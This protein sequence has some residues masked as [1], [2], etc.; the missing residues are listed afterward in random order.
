MFFQPQSS[1]TLELFFQGASGSATK[2]FS[3]YTGETSILNN[4]SGAENDF[5]FVD[6]RMFVGPRNSIYGSG[7]M[8]INWASKDFPIPQDIG[9]LVINRTGAY[10]YDWP[11]PMIV[12]RGHCDTDGSN[13]E[14]R[15][16]IG[17]G[18]TDY[19]GNVVDYGVPGMTY[20]SNNYSNNTFYP[21]SAVGSE[22]QGEWQGWRWVNQVVAG[23]PQRKFGVFQ[24]HIAIGTEEEDGLISNNNGNGYI[25][26]RKATVD[27]N[28]AIPNNMAIYYATD[29]NYKIF[30]NREVSLGPEIS[31]FSKLAADPLI[32]TGVTFTNGLCVLTNQHNGKA[33]SVNTT[34]NFTISVTGTVPEGF[35]CTCFM[36]GTGMVTFTGSSPLTLRNSLGLNKNNGRWSTVGLFR[37]GNNLFFYGDVT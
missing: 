4:V 23:P 2:V 16:F 33:L 31:G 10:Y 37:R 17:P 1:D 29:G 25:K 34:G 36:E 9:G 28:L 12:L 5:R 22:T 20:L 13:S 32:I 19:A 7:Q 24:T 8:N 6:S 14:M 26:L 30:T 18:F 27:P 21:S 11:D 3:V 35:S 15:Q